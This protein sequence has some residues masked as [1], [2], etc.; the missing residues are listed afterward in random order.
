MLAT[1]L[2][3]V[4][5]AVCRF[6]VFEIITPPANTPKGLVSNPLSLPLI[7][8]SLLR[9]LCRRR[10]LL[11]TLDLLLLLLLARRSWACFKLEHPVLVVC[12][13]LFGLAVQRFIHRRNGEARCL[14]QAGVVTYLR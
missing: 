4:H 12:T 6:T 8:D 3:T 14:G 1:Y 13:C 10:R 7:V 9:D 11:H 5:V 2:P